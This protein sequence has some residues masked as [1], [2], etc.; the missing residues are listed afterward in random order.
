MAVNE[1]SA[2]RFRRNL[3][4]MIARVQFSNDTIIIKKGGKDAAAL[5]DAALYRRIR[6]M[7]EAFDDLTGKLAAATKMCPKTKV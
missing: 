3:G 5:I 1:V 2:V 7:W 4:E 6:R